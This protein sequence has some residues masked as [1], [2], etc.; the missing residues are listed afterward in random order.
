MALTLMQF[1]IHFT[2]GYGPRV[3]EASVKKLQEAK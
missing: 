3:E 2:A 1:C